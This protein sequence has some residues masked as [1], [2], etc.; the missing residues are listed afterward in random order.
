MEVRYDERTKALPNDQLQRLFVQAGWSDAEGGGHLCHFNNPFVHSTLVVSAWDGERLVGAVR[1]L[2]DRTVRSVVYDLVVDA[3][4]R[5]QGIAR[6]ML[7]RCRAHFPD[8]EWLVQT[9]PERKSFY[10]GIGFHEIHDVFL[11]IP[12]K[13]F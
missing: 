12:S 11:R 5:G 7:R 4:Y 2:S 10:E 1:V 9:T 8:S 3:E 6:E 13:F